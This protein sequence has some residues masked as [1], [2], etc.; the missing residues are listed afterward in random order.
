MSRA[1]RKAEDLLRDFGVARPPV[2]LKEIAAGLGLTIVLEPYESG[3]EISAMLL[4]EHG[5]AVIGVNSRDSKLRQRFSIAHEI[6]HLMLH[7]GRLYLDGE[8]NFRDRT[9]TLGI[10]DEEVEA[11]LFASA[12]LMP[13]GMVRRELA[14]LL[15]INP[16]LTETK[17]VS[18]LS[19]K[20]EVSR[21]AMMIR[22]RSLGLLAYK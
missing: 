6:G 3:R 17:L 13:Q 12:F 8:V 11:N 4:R 7:K 10:D 14:L 15:S 1:D 2:P 22:L 19:S 9:S 5:R 18:E 21:S 20:F 16:N